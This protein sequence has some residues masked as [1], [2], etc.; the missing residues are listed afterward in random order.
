M[1]TTRC[2]LLLVLLAVCPALL[3][4]LSCYVEDDSAKAVGDNVWFCVFLSTNPVKKMVF[5]IKVEESAELVLQGSKQFALDSPSDPLYTW[6]AN[7]QT[8][9]FSGPLDCSNASEVELRGHEVSCPQIYAHSTGVAQL[10]NLV[11]NLRDGQ[12]T[13]S[14]FIQYH[15]VGLANPFSNINHF[16]QLAAPLLFGPV[17]LF[18]LFAQVSSFAWDNTCSGCSPSK[19]MKSSQSLTS[20]NFTEGS[21]FFQQGTCGEGPDFCTGT[22]AACNLRVFVTW[23]GTDK[24]GR[25]LISA[26]SRLSKL[27]GPTL[28]SLYDTLKEGY[29]VASRAIG[30]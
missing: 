6:V 17:M 12:A 16:R 2:P 23:A 24:R 30:Q 19:C 20:E 9:S 15:P 13:M 27:Q 11:V 25:H 28:A 8:G 7:S 22:P 3:R 4:A 21:E 18:Q 10:T 1:G 5:Q 26:G 29:N 14:R